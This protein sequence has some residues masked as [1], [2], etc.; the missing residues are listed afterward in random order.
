M[1]LKGDDPEGAVRY[2]LGL[3]AYH[4]RGRPKDIAESLR[5]H[6]EASER[7]NADAFF[8]LFVYAMNGI[9]DRSKAAFYLKEAA[10][11]DQPRA[12]ANLG[13]FYATGQMPGIEKNLTESV[14]WCQRAPPIL[15]SQERLRRWASWPCAEKAWCEI[16]E[17]PRHSS[18]VQ[19]A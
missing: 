1:A 12:C 14:R 8:E 2:L 10:K 9:G 5:L 3:M 7:E 16:K 17:G 4:G 15:A 19:R 11:H 18:T 6:L 13:A